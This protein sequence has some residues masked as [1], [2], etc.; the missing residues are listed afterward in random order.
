[1]ADVFSSRKR[2]EVMSR[3]RSRGNKDTEIAMIRLFR[4]HRITG[5]RRGKPL[6]GKPDFVF[7]EAKV[8]V[9]VDGCF[10]HGCSKHSKAPKT[11]SVYWYEKIQRNVKRDRQVS[12]ALRTSGWRVV[13]VWEHDLTSERGQALAARRIIRALT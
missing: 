6:F 8:I 5:W 7:N 4:S 12:N 10:W 11:N 3:I 2:S 13:R 9:F 1:M